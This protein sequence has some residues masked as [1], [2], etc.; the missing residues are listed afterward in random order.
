MKDGVAVS[1]A[2]VIILNLPLIRVAY[3][4]WGPIWRR[5]DR[6]NEDSQ[7]GLAIKILKEEYV[8][9]QK[10]ILRIRP[11][12]FEDSDHAMNDVMVESGFSQTRESHSGKP[13]TILVDLGCSENDMRKRLAKK[14][15]NSLSQSEKEKLTIRESF[16]EKGLE[17][18]QPLYEALKKRKNI[19]GVNLAELA[20]IQSKLSQAQKMRITL[21]E[22]DEGIIAGSVCSGL[23]DTALGIIGVTSEE[24][25]RRRAYYLLQWDEILWAKRNSNKAYDLNGINPVTNPLVYHFKSGL[26]GKEVTFL[27]LYDCYPNW[28]SRWLVK[29]NDKGM[30]LFKKGKVKKIIKKFLPA[31]R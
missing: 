17:L 10:M 12:G 16:D 29:I 19:E 2:L 15:R 28:I 3:V 25:R 14:W 1:L 8:H 13:R 27:G 6:P 23:G 7:F 26:R 4:P 18:I 5:R 30:K 9:R 11:N 22:N 24:G 31:R 21:C 20:L